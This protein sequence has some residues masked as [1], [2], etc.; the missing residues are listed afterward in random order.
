MCLF[1]VRTEWGI[2]HSR[3]PNTLQDFCYKRWLRCKIVL[4][5][6]KFWT[7]CCNLHTTHYPI[8]NE[9]I[10]TLF[11][12]IFPGWDLIL[13]GDLPHLPQ[14]MEEK[15]SAKYLQI[16]D[17]PNWRHTSLWHEDLTLVCKDLDCLNWSLLL[18]P[19]LNESLPS[20][21]LQGKRKLTIQVNYFYWFMM[22]TA[23]VQS[24]S[25]LIWKGSFGHVVCPGSSCLIVSVIQGKLISGLGFMH[26][27]GLTWL[28]FYWC[29]ML[30]NTE[31]NNVIILQRCK[32]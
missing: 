16:I 4:S 11:F 12:G 25:I 26:L 10:Q 21:L 15:E 7:N 32:K 27:D 30:Q 2:D 23:S 13:W 8:Q 29:Y 9:T 6:A 18:F 24:V 17:I 3:L 20:N 19:F 1:E 28:R 31:K 5:W 14:P 22:S